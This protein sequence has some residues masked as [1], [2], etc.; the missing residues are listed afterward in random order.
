MSRNR[1]TSAA[2]AAL[3]I[4][5]VSA[6]AD[7]AA[8]AMVQDALPIMYHSCASV[9]EQGHGDEAFVYDVVEKM[10]AVSLYNRQID[11]TVF[12]D[13]DADEARLHAAFVEALKAGCSADQNALLAGVVDNAVKA[14]LGL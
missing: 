11:I 7:D 1:F 6:S 8:D 10:T 14:A 3:L 9:V 4:A 2:L 12:S 13:S 5:P